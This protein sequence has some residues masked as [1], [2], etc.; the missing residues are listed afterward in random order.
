MK[1]NSKLFLVLPFITVVLG[2]LYLKMKE[3]DNA[4]PQKASVQSEKINQSKTNLSVSIPSGGVAT[5]SVATGI[6]YPPARTAAQDVKNLLSTNDPS[7]SFAA[8]KILDRCVNLKRI[9][10]EIKRINADAEA[11]KLD[12]YCQS[13]VQADY[14]IRVRLAEQAVVNK[15]PDASIAYF[16]IGPNGEPNDLYTRPSDPG[17]IE[18]RAN[19]IRYLREAAESGEI[20]AV[21]QLGIVY[22]GTTGEQRD[23]GKLLGYEYALDAMQKRDGVYKERRSRIEMIGFLEKQASDQ[24]REEAQSILK[25][26]AK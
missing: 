18:W 13:L 2:I 22:S 5:E 24:Q 1:V 15:T 17:I 3:P 10:R 26:I 20:N 9:S 11:V 12:L 19:A 7:N 21:A 8:L 16:A 23:L 25:K 4:T 6:P 14:N